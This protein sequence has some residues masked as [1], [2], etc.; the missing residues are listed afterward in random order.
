MPLKLYSKFTVSASTLTP[1]EDPFSLP[2]AAFNR[3]VAINVT[4]AFVA[5]QQ[6]VLGFS[7]L[8][9]SASKIGRA[10]V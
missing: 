3:D 1:P 4:S 5:A 9:A 7:Q 8:P 10:H 6:A 2:L